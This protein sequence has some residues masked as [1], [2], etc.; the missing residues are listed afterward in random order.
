MNENNPTYLN[1]N[2]NAHLKEQPTPRPENINQSPIRSRGPQRKKEG[3]THMVKAPQL[4]TKPGTPNSQTPKNEQNNKNG[5]PDEDKSCRNAY[6]TLGAILLLAILLGVLW[7]VFTRPIFEAMKSAIVWIEDLPIP[8]NI[9]IFLA[10]YI[11]A[12]GTG[13]PAST[14]LTI[15]LAYTLDSIY[16]PVFYY[17]S[18]L[19]IVSIIHYYIAVKCLTENMKQNYRKQAL[20]KTVLQESEKS[21]CL[22]SFL[23]QFITAPA[24]LLNFILALA[25]IGFWMFICNV[26]LYNLMYAVLIALVGK[27]LK[28]S[29]DAIVSGSFSEMNTYEV[30]LLIFTICAVII[31]IVFLIFVVL[32]LRAKVKKIEEEEA[33]KKNYGDFMDEMKPGETNAM[34]RGPNG[35]EI[36]GVN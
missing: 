26:L 33:K 23:I 19:G 30:V 2:N 17:V 31:S 18:S 12:Q 22:I 20:Y 14:L 7:N 24:L 21:P 34:K 10:I 8:L 32:Y 25:G 6:I 1:N 13:I 36:G 27:N 11:T 15:L 9:F 4:K 28:D 5:P 35:E 3:D 16:M 29:E